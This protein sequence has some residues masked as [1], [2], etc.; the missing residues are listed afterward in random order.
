MSKGNLTAAEVIEIV[1]TLR[2]SRD[3]RELR[4][5]VKLRLEQHAMTDVPYIPEHLE[6]SGKVQVLNSPS[7]MS[8]AQQIG[9]AIAS[10]QTTTTAIPG[11]PDYENKADVAEKCYA[12]RRTA[13]FSPQVVN[14]MRWKQMVVG[15]GFYHL[16]AGDVED[17]DPW[18]V[19]SP[20]PL[21]VYFE[22]IPTMSMRP[23]VVGREYEQMMRDMSKWYSAR[24]ERAPVYD[25]KSGNWYTERVS[26]DRSRDF[27]DAL[28]KTVKG[29]FSTYRI[30]EYDDGEWTYVV[31]VNK[32]KS[33]RGN[34]RHKDGVMLWDRKNLTEG[35]SY[36][37]VPGY[38]TGSEEMREKIL[39]HLW[40]AQ[41]VQNQIDAINTLRF[42]RSMNLK[43]QVL[44]ER[45][46]E[47]FKAMLQLGFMQ[48]V[49]EGYEVTGVDSIVELNGKP[50]FWELPEDKDLAF[51]ESSKKE[52]LAGYLNTE[53]A[54]TKADVLKDSPVRNVQLALGARAQQ[55]AFLLTY[56]DIGQAETLKMWKETLCDDEGYPEDTYALYA[57]DKS[58]HGKGIVKPGTRL[59]MN[60][61]TFDF[62][63]TVTV[64]TASMSPEEQDFLV[65]SMIGRKQNRIAT[66]PQVLEA[67][68]Q[69]VSEQEDLLLDEDAYEQAAAYYAPW[70]KPTFE[71]RMAE[72]HG[73][74]IQSPMTDS[75]G[76]Q[77]APGG[78]GAPTVPPNAF[79]MP[80]VEGG[81]SQ[82]AQATQQ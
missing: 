75:L 62:D 21:S 42:T 71:A 72:N 41:N 23:N 28:P 60:K 34:A 26:E 17:D 36:V 67:I 51:L 29:Q 2:E 49:P 46:P 55:Q 14:Q 73:I 22:F 65:Q 45:S 1:D 78:G 53:L 13:F 8:A 12:L 10:Y 79:P 81:Q 59:E 77:P 57:K 5:D 24:E 7:V 32:A 20:A 61:D 11:H 56:Q 3:M 18:S 54:L 66:W 80:N 33:G 47:L 6:R 70:L 69:N 58:V 50:H 68:Y 19:E 63:H 9:A 48:P 40:P 39:P 35:C 64:T 30:Y 74:L 4:D 43:P 52:E 37:L 15:Y 38:M 25:S 27:Y 82:T 16:V 44:M 76:A 31:G